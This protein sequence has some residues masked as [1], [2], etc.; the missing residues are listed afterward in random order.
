M[1]AKEVEGSTELSLVG[2][3]A[4]PFKLE[5][6]SGKSISSTSLKGKAYV[7]FF[8]PKDNTPGC[9]TESCD[10]RD[11]EENFRAAGVTVLGVSP[12]SVKS[13]VGFANKHELPFSLLSDPE[14]EL[15]NAYGVWV[16]KK[17]YGREY[18]GI[19][20]STFLV[21]SNGKVLAEWRKVRVKEHVQAVLAEADQ[22]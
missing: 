4:P 13:H 17:N 2:K 10:F 5:D 12:D 16:L 7:L 21:G 8:Y 22:S 6:Q 19:V 11:Q 1:A 9:T 14:K 15:A 20:R 18:W 3:K